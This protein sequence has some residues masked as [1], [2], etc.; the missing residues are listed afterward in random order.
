MGHRIRVEVV[1]T[2][3]DDLTAGAHS[4]E[5]DELHYAGLSAD[6]LAQFIVDAIQSRAREF[7]K[8][9]GA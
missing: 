9:R 2:L 4:V 6:E 1:L 8:V 7:R 3:A 5:P